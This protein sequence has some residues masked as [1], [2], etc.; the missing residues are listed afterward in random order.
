MNTKRTFPFFLFNF[1]LFFNL[2]AFENPWSAWIM[3]NNASVLNYSLGSEI[4]SNISYWQLFEGT[5]QVCVHGF[6]YFVSIYLF[7]N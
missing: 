3:G 4:S 6:R 5:K 2:R 7:I 1:V